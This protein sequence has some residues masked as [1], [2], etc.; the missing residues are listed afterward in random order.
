MHPTFPNLVVVGAN[1][2][3]AFMAFERVYN[4]PAC[5]P[6]MANISE[7]HVSPSKV[8]DGDAGMVGFYLQLGDSLW[9]VAMQ[10]ETIDAGEGPVVLPKIVNR[11]RIAQVGGGRACWDHVSEP[12][13]L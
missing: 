9:E 3:M 10:P 12:A 2:G 13:C 1:T 8:G 7:A 6:P 11:Q 5:I 4:I